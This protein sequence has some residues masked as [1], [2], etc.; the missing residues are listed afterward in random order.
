MTETEKP[1]YVGDDGV[2][3]SVREAEK[4]RYGGLTQEEFYEK[5]PNA[6]RPGQSGNPSGRP[7]AVVNRKTARQI[8]EQMGFNPIE[9]AIRMVTESPEELRAMGITEPVSVTQ[10]TKLLMWVGDKMFASVKAVDLDLNPGKDKD[11]SRVQLYFPQQDNV[12]PQKLA[13]ESG[14][15]V[16]E[17]SAD[18]AVAVDVTPED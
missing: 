15:P 18:N 10:K 16:M 17:A 5:Y 2:P 4:E 12:N 8:A 14:K 9:A 3:E 13:N 1:D 7:L 11:E 6:F